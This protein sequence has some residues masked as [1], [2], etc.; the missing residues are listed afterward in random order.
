MQQELVRMVADKTG[1]SED[2]ARKAADTVLGYLKGKL[3]PQMASQ[4]DNVA[5][6]QGGTGDLGSMASG[7]GSKLTG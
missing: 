6:G 2:Q 5:S 7:L 3:P 4:L 1:I